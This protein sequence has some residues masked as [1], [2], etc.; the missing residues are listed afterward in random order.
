MAPPVPPV[1]EAPDAT[2]GLWR[3]LERPF[4]LIPVAEALMG[5]RPE[6]VEALGAV[7]VC[8]SPEA[9]A[10]LAAMPGLSRALTTSV[11][12]QA[13]RARG[14]VR[15]P[16]LWSE[17]MSARA[18]SFG[19]EDLFVCSAPQRDYDTPANRAL[20][21]A[22]RVLGRSA[23]ALDRAPETW[24]GDARL[25]AALLAA[26]AAHHW[27]DHPSLAGVSRERIGARDIKRVRGGKSANRYAPALALLD[28]AGEPL[29]PTELVALCDHRTRRQH[30]V[31]LAV[32]QEL[33]ARGLTLP[34]LRLEGAGLL[35]GPVTYVHPSRRMGAA[36][37]HGIL[38]GHVLIDVGDPAPPQHE[39]AGRRSGDQ[40]R[41]D[42]SERALAAR[43][44]GRR[45]AVIRNYRDVQ[46]AVDLAV[47][48]ARELLHAEAR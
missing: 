14:E 19:D 41:A 13:V 3:R 16:V 25:E 36:Q 10:L 11:N 15:G 48:S 37:A 35:S 39:P 47:R 1:G 43:S 22:L 8:S 5:V 30:W 2:A 9:A 40:V 34:P 29:T 12:S 46:L 17:T 28:V 4:E 26:R 27:T 33:E 18:S 38:V 6:V 20:V 24:R 45:V 31:L 21:Q 32:L 44:G 42:A 23:A 7:R